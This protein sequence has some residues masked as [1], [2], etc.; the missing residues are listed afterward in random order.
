VALAPRERD[1]WL[2]DP[3]TAGDWAAYGRATGADPAALELY[4]LRWSLLDI[5][6]F[7]AAL[8]APHRDDGNIRAAWRG[9]RHYLSGGE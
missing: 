9:L 4:E 8:R 3:R 5:C 6:A 7:T 1:L 2:L